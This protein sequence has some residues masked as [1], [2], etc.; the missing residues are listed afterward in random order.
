MHLQ[1]R[2][3][4]EHPLDRRLGQFFRAITFD[5]ERFESHARNVCFFAVDLSCDLVGDVQRDFH[6]LSDARILGRFV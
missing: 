4:T 1:A 2:I 3:E 5:S 6:Y